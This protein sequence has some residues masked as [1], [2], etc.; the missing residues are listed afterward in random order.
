MLTTIPRYH[1]PH[2]MIVVCDLEV[3]SDTDDSYSLSSRTSIL[4]KS[5]RFDRHLSTQRKDV[6]SGVN[7]IDK[8]KVQHVSF[9]ISTTVI[10]CS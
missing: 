9:N 8:M 5:R 2:A 10:F 6:V 7:D 4:S 1:M 3:E